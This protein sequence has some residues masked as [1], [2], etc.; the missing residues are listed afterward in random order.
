MDSIR[1]NCYIHAPVE[2]VFDAV[3]DHESFFAGGNIK[4][5]RLE[6]E[7]SPERNGLG[8]VRLIRTPAVRFVEEIT[9]F[10]RPVA[11]EY[12][13]R[14]CSLPIDHEG[15]KLVFTRRGD[16]TEIDWTATFEV[17]VALI[18]AALTRRWRNALVVEF[19]RLL[20]QAKVRLEDDGA[21]R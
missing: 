5:A 16:G 1:V 7:G 17:P 3:S 18:G 19:T 6:R 14:E 13:I 10:E 4:V 15:S 2:T 8:C 11:F 9:S 12:R 20:L 21:R